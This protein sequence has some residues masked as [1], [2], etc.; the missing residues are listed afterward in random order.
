MHL[1][2]IHIEIVI[3]LL[4]PPTLSLSLKG[5]TASSED[6]D[7]NDMVP[8]VL[9]DRISHGK[10]WHTRA[11][12]EGLAK[13]PPCWK[14][15]VCVFFHMLLAQRILCFA[16]KEDLWQRTPKK[17]AMKKKSPPFSFESSL[18]TR[19]SKFRLS[20][21][22]TLLR[23]RKHLPRTFQKNCSD[24]RGTLARFMVTRVFFK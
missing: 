12:S 17:E 8:R 14:H 15:V 1:L 13:C 6:Y 24:A 7:G 18:L 3:Y 11:G 2:Y 23:V 22:E 21:K 10:F 5:S 19:C 16:K 9:C 4:P 20:V